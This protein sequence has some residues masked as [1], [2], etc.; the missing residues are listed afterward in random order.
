AAGRD[1]ERPP[2]LRR[3]RRDPMADVRLVRRSGPAPRVGMVDVGA[4]VGCAGGRLGRTRTA[5]GPVGSGRYPV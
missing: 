1:R 3:G 4:S 5:P 2:R